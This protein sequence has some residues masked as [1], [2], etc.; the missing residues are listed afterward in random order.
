MDC[1]EPLPSLKSPTV[2]VAQADDEQALYGCLLALEADN[3]FGLPRS[4]KRVWETINTCC[5]M[6]GGV[7]GVI[8]APDGSI[9]ASVG[10]V[11]SQAAWYTDEWCLR[12]IWL[13]VRPGHRRGTGYADRLV[14]FALEHR[15]EMSRRIGR[16][17]L[18]LTGPNSR[19]RLRAKAAWWARWSNKVGENY[20]VGG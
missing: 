4:D 16:N 9:A 6:Q 8:D 10:I 17:I 13:F 5:R 7:A 11:A 2:R 20:V 1:T 18:L 3:T 19:K 15:L 14:E 12:E